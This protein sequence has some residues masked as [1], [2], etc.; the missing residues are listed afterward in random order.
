MATVYRA[1]RD[2]EISEAVEVFLAGL[3]Q[4]AVRMSLP[5][6]TAYTPA[7]VQPL[8]RHLFDTGIFEVAE[9]DGRLVTVCAAVLRDD[10]CF[11]SMFWTR[12]E[13]L[14]RGLGKPLLERVFEQARRRGARRF[15]TWSSL[16]FAA[17]GTYLKLGLLP[18]GPI[19]TFEGPL[20]QPIEPP[21]AVQVRELE[22]TTAATVDG[23]VR[24]ARRPID[25]PYFIARG[26]RGFQTEGAHGVTGYFYVN[27][28]VIG[29][30]AWLHPGDGES[31][32]ACALREAAS[33]APRV[34][35]MFLGTNGPA[36]RAAAA[37]GLRLVGT[38][39]WLRS[40]PFGK[41]D[42]YLPSG[43]AVF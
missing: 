19:F 5:A 25:H 36:L 13:C 39:H 3:G 37:H 6:P 28:G 8:Y 15:A 41:L 21:A 27:A 23:V 10:L 42:Q 22:P 29:P 1:L 14:Q 30:A 12:P 4:Y 24:A 20:K 17:V 33:D 18:G 2:D 35:L 16:D 31:V 38:A 34:K 9:Q 32:L 43:P 11:L 40:A 7:A 26:A